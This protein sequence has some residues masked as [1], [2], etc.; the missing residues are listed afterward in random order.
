MAKVSTKQTIKTANSGL[1]VIFQ[2]TIPSSAPTKLN[3]SVKVIFFSPLNIA[4]TATRVHKE[5]LV[6]VI[7]VPTPPPETI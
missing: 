1:S 5:A 7:K 3:L 6:A 4:I 2:T